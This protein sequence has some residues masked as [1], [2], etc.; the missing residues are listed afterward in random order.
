MDNNYRHIVLHFDHAEKPKFTERKG[1]GWIEFGIDNN[2]PQYLLDLYNE[3]PKHGAIVKSKSTYIYGQGWDTNGIAN[4][5]GESW[6]E[7]LKKAIKDDELYRGYYMQVIWNRSGK[8]SDVFH[9]DFQKVRT[10]KDRTIFYVKN[11]WSDLREKA[12]EYPAFNLSNPTGS[13]IYSYKEYNS[14]SEVYPIPSYY[15]GLNYIESDI[16]VSRHI[17]GNAKQGFVGSTLINLNN[18][19]PIG[20]EHKGEVERQLLKKFTG[21]SGKRVVIMFNKSKDNAAEIQNLGNTMLTKEDFTNINNLIQQEIFASH[22]ITSAELFGI[23]VPGALGSRSAMRDSFEIFNKTYVNDRQQDLEQ[24]FTKLRN[25]K[26]ESGDFK[27]VPIEPLKFEF[28]EAIM[29]ANLTQNEIR[30]L[31]GKEPIQN[32]N[33]L[34]SSTSEV[35]PSQ[36]QSNDAIRNLTGRQYQNVM[37]IV[38]H[39]GS[40]KLTKQQATLM[41]KSGFGLSDADVNTFLGID[42]DPLTDD[43][44]QKFNSQED[45]RI[46]NEFA[47][48]GDNWEDYD[49]LNRYEAFIEPI[50]I[51]QLEANV[52]EMIN[53][54]KR[55]NPEGIAKALNVSVDDVLK[56]LESLEKKKVIATKE[57]KVGNDVIIEREVLKPLSELQGKEPKITELFIRY[58]YEWRVPAKQQNFNTSRPFCQKMMTLSAGK[59]NTGSKT[60]SMTDIQNMSV[61]LGYSVLDRCGGFWNNNGTIEYQCRHQWVANVMTKKQK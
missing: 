40:G 36:M 41:L 24:V 8:I 39:F 13:Q 59:G 9:I 26:G 7:L 47:S 43:E 28:S 23:S 49:L 12:R 25:Y 22:Q 16:Q 4:S 32:G 27:I 30:E 61:R 15:Q 17:L 37:R 35:A 45:D 18:G 19:D 34:P 42:D 14:F 29:A 60:W 53:N 38:R 3:S 44:I 10:N 11:D 58:T 56:T 48:C 57:T 51:Y 31:M 50:V 1:K 20:E 46:Y 54:D 55:V 33:A 5:T 6:N 2:Y 21:E 52:I